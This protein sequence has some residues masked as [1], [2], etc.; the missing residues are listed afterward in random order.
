MN[1]FPPLKALRVFEAA[2]RTES[3]N[4]AAEALNVTPSAVSHQVKSLEGY[5]GVRLFQRRSRQVVLTP[6][7]RSYLVPI[8]NALEEIR[9]ATE[10]L[11]RGETTGT[12]TLSSAPSFAVGWLMPRLPQFQLEHPEIEVRLT[13]SVELV[14]FTGSDVDVAIRTGKGTWPKLRGHRLMAEELIPVCSPA[15]SRQGRGLRRP[16][17]LREATL[18][19]E[20]ARLGQWRS[21]LA[22]VGVEG[23]DAERGPKLQGATMVVEAAVAGLGV[24][25]A[26]RS[27]LEKHLEDGRLVVPFDV[28]VPTESAYYLA[29][30]EERENNAKII[31]FKDW[32]LG[33]LNTERE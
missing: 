15:L 28:E 29:Y 20:L 23:V 26:S 2:A 18:I 19:H 30:P 16:E 9:I 33:V 14:D 27:M 4:L 11:R 32:I 24:A 25:I 6:E 22:A 21:W 12:L 7:G 5:L 8:R 31:G 3:F 10:Q 1:R 13:S 17:D